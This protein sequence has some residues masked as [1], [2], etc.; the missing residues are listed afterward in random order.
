M[1]GLPSSRRRG[2]GCLSD[3]ALDRFR[4]GELAA[5][6]HLSTCGACRA[7]LEALKH[8]DQRF[9][10]EVWVEGEARKAKRRL[11]Y[12]GVGALAAAAAV[13][14][15]TQIPNANRIKGGDALSLALR[16]PG[17]HTE[18]V[19]PGQTLSPGDAVRFVVNAR[20]AGAA[21]VVLDLDSRGAVSA[22]APAPGADQPQP[23]RAG[24]QVLD[25]AV[26]LDDSVGPERLV[27]LLCA[28]P[29]SAAEAV[30]AG[31]RALAKAGGDLGAVKTLDLPC[32]EAWFRFEK[33]PR[34]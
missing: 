32:R 1:S 22:F 8:E 16:E 10:A 30:A 25:G 34:R 11:P 13:L 18:A 19:R 3:L 28:T 14:L 26:V 21:V 24:R 29:L 9:E 2:E 27:A 33:A 6:A 12:A 23:F 20:E 4:A 31:Q 17:G 15:V 7:R 5:P